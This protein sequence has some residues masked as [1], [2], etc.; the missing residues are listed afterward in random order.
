MKDVG[1]SKQ[2]KACKQG[3]GTKI[4]QTLPYNPT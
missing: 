1:M 2:K 3:C 4:K